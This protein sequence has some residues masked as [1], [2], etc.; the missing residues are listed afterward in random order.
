MLGVDH[1][2]QPKQ[3]RHEESDIDQYVPKVEQAMW[4]HAICKERLDAPPET[5]GQY[6]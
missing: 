4:A 2:V 5:L 1:S 6:L 3:A